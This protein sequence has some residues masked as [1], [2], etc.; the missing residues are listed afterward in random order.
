[1]TALVTEF[2]YGTLGSVMPGATIAPSPSAHTDA[3]VTLDAG[4]QPNAAGRCMTVSAAS[5]I[6][7]AT[8]IAA[9]RSYS[10]SAPVPHAAIRVYRVNLARFHIGPVAII[11]ELQNRLAAG[12]GAEVEPVIREYW[13]PTGT[14]YLQ[15]V[16]APSLTVLEEVPAA[17]ER[18]V[19][20]LRWVH[21]NQDCERAQFL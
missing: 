13:Q 9:I 6:K 14:W 11:G 5:S 21:Y 3:D 8:A 16:L 19:Y 2:Y 7:D 17:T 12:R 10:H 4:K 1:M 15:E 18:D 20:K